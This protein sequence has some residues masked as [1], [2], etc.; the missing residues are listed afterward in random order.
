M[1]RALHYRWDHLPVDS[2][3]P[4]LSRQRVI[5][6]QAMI[7]RVR[8]EEGCFVATHSH[9][10]EQFSLVERGELEFGIGQPGTP[11]YYTVRVRAGELL[12]LPSQ[13]PHSALAIEATLV[14]DIF[15]PPSQ[16]TGIDTL[17]KPQH[18]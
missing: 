2:P 8:L 7:S 6:E 10:N 1:P 18:A 9:E 11:D 3:L 4:R 12:H 15:A 5:G 14:L 16:G 17:G 13:V